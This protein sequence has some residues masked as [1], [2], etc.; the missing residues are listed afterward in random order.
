MSSVCI[1]FH[2]AWN[3]VGLEK[4]KK[5][6]AAS[7]QKGVSFIR[8][9]VSEKQQI[10]FMAMLLS[11]LFL[12]I[13][14]SK[15]KKSTVR[16]NKW[17]GLCCINKNRQIHANG[18]GEWKGKEK[19]SNIVCRD[20]DVPTHVRLCV[21]LDWFQIASLGCL[22]AWSFPWWKGPKIVK[23]CGNKEGELVCNVC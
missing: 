17:W 7:I 13:L 9:W 2:T 23:K 3:R 14:F 1:K 19:I 18:R 15:E 12:F 21:L 11:Y 20:V 4:A 6:L 16:E 8:K 22:Q 5:E 10:S